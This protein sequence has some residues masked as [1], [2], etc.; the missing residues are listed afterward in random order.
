MLLIRLVLGLTTLANISLITSLRSNSESLSPSI[1]VR[2]HL[3]PSSPPSEISL[4]TSA[5]RRFLS[6]SHW[7]GRCVSFSPLIF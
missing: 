2:L 7:I 4:I 1:P 6:L 5:E 3:R